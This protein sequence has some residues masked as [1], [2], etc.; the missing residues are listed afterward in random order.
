VLRCSLALKTLGFKRV[1][2]IEEIEAA[3]VKLDASQQQQLAQWVI[4]H[5]G[6]RTPQGRPLLRD[7]AFTPVRCSDDAFAPLTEEE[8][9][10]FGIA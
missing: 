1:R 10:A 2:T 3:I 9:A 4:A 5:C 8:L 7:A 6:G